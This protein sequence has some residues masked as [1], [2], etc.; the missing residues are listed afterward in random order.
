MARAARQRRG[1]SQLPDGWLITKFHVAFPGLYYFWGRGWRC[2]RDGVI[3]FKLFLLLL[4]NVDHIE[5]E[6]ELQGARSTALGIGLAMN[7]KDSKV[8]LATRSLIRRAYPSED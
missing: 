4:S 6:G 1:G 7:G 3:P 8:K 5:A 2:T